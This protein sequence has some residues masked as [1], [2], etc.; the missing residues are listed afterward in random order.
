[1]LT[2]PRVTCH[3]FFIG[4][5]GNAAAYDC[6]PFDSRLIFAFYPSVVGVVASPFMVACVVVALGIVIVALRLPHP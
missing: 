6:C 5:L 1:V 3:D 2:L 4:R